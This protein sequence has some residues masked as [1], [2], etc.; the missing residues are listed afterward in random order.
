M[1]SDKLVASKLTLHAICN[2][3]LDG[4]E[5]DGQGSAQGGIVLTA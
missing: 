1:L 3:T 5:E 4:S 2:S